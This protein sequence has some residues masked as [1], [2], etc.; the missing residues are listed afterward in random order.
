MQSKNFKILGTTLILILCAILYVKNNSSSFDEKRLI[1]QNYLDNSPFKKTKTLSKKERRKIEL[2]PNAYSE[3]MW[4]LSINPSTGR[5]EPEKVFNLQKE[6]RKYNN[7]RVAGVPGEQDV[8]ETKWVQRGPYNVGGRTKAMLWDPNDSSNNTVF[9]GGVSGGIFKNN[10]ITNENSEWDLITRNIPQN[11]AVSS[12]TVDPNDSNTFYVGTGESYTSGDAL[13]NGL[14]KSSDGGN[15]WSKTF[16]GN[17]ETSY[18]SGYNEVKITSPSSSRTY[19]YLEASY[20]PGLTSTGIEG[21]AVI[22]LDASGEGS[23]ATDGCSSLQNSSE[24][25]NKIAIIDRGECYFAEKTVNAQNAGAK[26]LIIV[27]NETDPLLTGMSAPNDGS[28]DISKI[29]IPTIQISLADGNHLKSL[30]NSQNVELSVKK[31]VSVAEG[32]TIVPGTFYINDVVVR[33]NNGVSEIYAAVGTSFYRDAAS[34]LFGAE[35]YGLYKSTNGGKD[36]TRMSIFRDNSNNYI[37]P[38]DLEISPTDNKL[39]VSSTRDLYG[40]GG[41]GVWVSD[42][43]GENFTKKYQIENGGRRTEIE[44]T[45]DNT[46]WILGQCSDNPST[47]TSEGPVCIFKGPNGLNGSVVE[48]TLPDDAGPGISANDFTRGQSFYDLMIESDPSD[49]NKIYVGGIDLFRTDNAGV[50]SSNPW[51]QLSH[52]YGYNGLPYAHADQHGS[53]IL[54][55]DPSKVLFGNDGGIFYSQNSGTTLTSRNNNYHTSQYYT[56]AVAPSTMFENHSTQV[57]GSDSRYG[58]Y[59]YKDVPQGGPEQDVFAGGLQDNGTQFSVNIIAGD[60][61]SSVAARSGG[62]DG[63]A[64][65]FSQDVE[66][67][68]FI[69]N[70]VYNK[71]IEAVNMNGSQ[72]QRFNLLSE[73]GSNGDFITTQALDSNLGIVYSYYG[74]GSYSSIIAIYDWDDFDPND[75]NTNAPS[76]SISNPLMDGGVTALKVSQYTEE[77]STLFVGTDNGKFFK[78]E[79]ANVPN[80]GAIGA[81]SEQ[82]WT[83]LTGNEFLGSVSD[84]ELGK[85]ENHIFVTFHNYGVDNIFYSSDGGQSWSK[86]EGSLPDIPVRAIL[87]NPFIEDEVIVGTELGVWYTKDF[88][89]TNP[90]WLQANSGMNDVR[91]TDLDLRDD[92]KVFAATYGLG[93]YSSYFTESEV[94]PEP[95]LITSLNVDE[96]IIMQGNSKSF[97]ISYNALNGF[98]EDVTFEITG[99]PSETTA[100]PNPITKLIN[101]EGVIEFSINVGVDEAGGDY[102]LKILAKSTLANQEHDLLLRVAS[103]DNDGDGVLNIEDNCPDSYNPN[104]EDIDGD[105]V[106]DVCDSSPFS[107]NVFMFSHTNENCRLS[108][109]GTANLVIVD[110]N[111]PESIQFSVKLTSDNNSFSHTAEIVQNSAWTTKTLSAGKYELCITTQAISNFKQCFSFTITEPEDIAVISDVVNNGDTMNLTLSGSSNYNIT[112]NNKTIS[113]SDSNASIKLK[114]G[115]NTI[116]VTGDKECQG[117]YEETIFNSEDILLSPNPTSTSSRLWIGGEDKNVNVSMFDNAGRL[118]WT[119]QNDVPSSRSIDI[120]VSNLRAGLYY[121]KVDSE[122]VKKTAKLIKE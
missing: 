75:R 66:N 68:Y 7:Q 105:L 62:G 115:L 113:T 92:G 98:N 1:H 111:I 103:D 84:I 16:G 109:D 107:N 46:V 23:T 119:N 95:E 114:K 12:I 49:S 54:E 59:F 61:G 104:Q 91:V 19:R 41:G 65:M 43:S 44:V 6:L 76:Y 22:G 79:K 53:V 88:K 34:T 90:T 48:I 55:S 73:S 63:A 37:Q 72:S 67:K 35:D 25:N 52:W 87:Q 45:N 56:V 21:G 51:N 29:N 110:T 4:E 17:T 117:I 18:V 122:T 9:A 96:L 3:R 78:V 97:E 40:L 106:G 85:D 93:V 118:L 5:T 30:L 116:R 81:V 36:W 27:N 112:H 2:P 121:I 57:Y 15:T 33:N 71:S 83:N 82:V 20:G 38:I 28:V 77:S 31:T 8:N 70:Y 39:W 58:N 11:L 74:S 89:S 26:L 64:T 47:T 69:Q 10:D 94:D 13:G 102:P 100:N 32:Y 120:Q 24:I 108:D 99:L 86:K 42:D 101:D 80:S 50:S 60:N 14:W